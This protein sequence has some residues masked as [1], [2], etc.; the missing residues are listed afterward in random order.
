MTDTPTATNQTTLIAVAGIG[1]FAS[2]A[3]AA[4]TAFFAYLMVKVKR[5]TESTH[6][7]VNHDR[8][9]M[10]ESQAQTLRIASLEHP[11]D[12]GLKWAASRAE[13]AAK[14]AFNANRAQFPRGK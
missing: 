10:L 6:A 4:I 5:V 12:D 11:T 3:S 13:Q 1:A 8:Q 14:D 7:I 2:I 9:V